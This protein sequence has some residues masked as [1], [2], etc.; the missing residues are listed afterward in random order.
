MLPSARILG[1]YWQFLKLNLQLYCGPTHVI[2]NTILKTYGYYEHDDKIN[3]VLGNQYDLIK[4]FNIKNIIQGYHY[5]IIETTNKLYG[6]GVNTYG[7][8]GLGH[9][10]NIFDVPR[11][12]QMKNVLKVACGSRHTLILTTSGVYGCGD[13]SCG[14]L[15]LPYRKYHTLTKLNIDDVVDIICGDLYT[16]FKLKDNYY[17]CGYNFNGQLGH[18]LNCCLDLIQINLPNIIHIQCHSL[19]TVVNCQDGVYLYAN[20]TCQKIVNQLAD[21]IYC[22]YDYILFIINDFLYGCGEH[23]LP[24]TNNFLNMLQ[25]INI[26]DVIYI[27]GSHNY[28]ILFTK[29]Q[30]YLIGTSPHLLKIRYLFDDEMIKTLYQ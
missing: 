6:V 8:L 21:F 11:Q 10:I 14:Q 9:Y 25:Q 23:N 22:G 19:Y 5:H 13:N 17:G 15:Y 24:T 2:I 18:H 27:N 20:K 26:K 28:V 3:N 30:I 29:T 4:D 16:I 1:I 7:Q 12:I